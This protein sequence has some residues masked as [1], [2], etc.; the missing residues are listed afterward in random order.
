M[1]QAISYFTVGGIATLLHVA[2]A[3]TLNSVIGMTP[4]WSNSIAVFCAWVV[5]YSL[6]WQWTFAAV[7][8]H[9]TSMPRF[10]AISVAGFGLNQALVYAFAV[11]LGWPFWI[12][13]V[14]VVL[15]VPLASYVASKV[16]AFVPARHLA[17]RERASGA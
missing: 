13:L 8:P 12:A 1:R 6:N 4:L 16:W 7:S 17:R 10:L 2:I 11:K 14:P 5:S 3:L 9:R 15:I